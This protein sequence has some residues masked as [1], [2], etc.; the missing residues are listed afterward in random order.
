MKKGFVHVLSGCI[1]AAAIS[2]IAGMVCLA[3]V[4]CEVVVPKGYGE[5]E[6]NYP[7]VY[8]MPEDGYGSTDDKLID[9]F[10]PAEVGG[11]EMIWVCPTFTDE[12]DP[13][14][15]LTQLV[16][17]IDA[18]YQ[19]IPDTAYR[20]IVGAGSGGYLAYALGM[21]EPEPELFANIASV[22]GNFV[23]EDNP[24]YDTYGDVYEKINRLHDK[25]GTFYENYYTYMDAPSE[26]DW[27]WM[28]YST[29]NI[30]LMFL[31]WN[32]LI[33]LTT[34]EFTVREGVYDEAF[35]QES[36]ARITDRLSAK[37]TE[38][39]AEGSLELAQPVLTGDE[40]VASASYALT[41]TDACETFGQG[42]DMLVKIAVTDAQTGEVISEEKCIERMQAQP[43][44]YEG[45][46]EIENP[47]SGGTALVQ[48]SVNIFGYEVKLAEAKLIR[49][50]QTGE[51]EDEQLIDLM[52]SWYFQYVGAADPYEGETLDKETFSSWP[53]VLPTLGNWE[54]GFG[55]VTKEWWA[56][57]G[58]GWYARSFTVPEDFPQDELILSIGYMD[59]RG[60]VY[61]NGTRVGATGLDEHGQSTD[62]TTWAV[63]SHYALDPA[64]LNYGGENQIL[65]HVCNDPP[66]GAGGW[67]NGP[68]GIYSKAAF[69]RI[70]G[71]ASR[72]QEESYA[73]ALAASAQMEKGTVEERYMV[74]L[75]K[76]YD[77][78]DRFYPTVYL[79]HQYNSDHTSYQ[80][81]HI[82]Q[83]LDQAIEAGELEDM[84]VVVPNSSE[85]SF[86]LGDWERMV[87]EELVPLIDDKYRTIPDARYRL[88]AGASMGGQGAFGIALRNPDVFSGAISFFG[89]FSMGQN[90]SPNLIA[91][92]E[93][94]EY[95]RYFSLYFMCGNQDMYGFEIPAIKLDKA[96]HEKAVP[97]TFFVE[98]GE[99]NSAFYLP[100]FISALST[101][102]DG[103]YHSDEGLQGIAEGK[104]QTEQKE[105]KLSVQASLTVKDDVSAYQNQIPKS[106]YTQEEVQPLSGRLILE[107]MQD[108]KCVDQEEISGYR[109]E[110]GKKETFTFTLPENVDPAKDYSISW[111]MAVLDQI[112]LLDQIA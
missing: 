92:D 35:K 71:G 58:W 74:Y 16:E 95:L 73:S 69:D 17:Q 38:G 80:T 46:V 89:A 94:A 4:P 102:R 7:V 81:D 68:V 29:N 62:E 76:D 18:N 5:T 104:L 110:G 55:N 32:N 20:A 54:A 10:N 48:L 83:L 105:E 96:L 21:T 6:Q 53:Q 108:G 91:Q 45:T 36:F 106:S 15:Q 47:L 37:F 56:N 13:K 66:Y 22:R 39:L 57:I 111:K 107:V 9:W 63:Y 109:L 97:H 2:G 99:H 33:P 82:D 59:D 93:S 40:Q 101:T 42:G 27:S 67:Y 1:A 61:V 65:V 79:L 3:D 100:Y 85:D 28:D 70:N 52:G 77:E 64:L 112:I 51:A 11:M 98:N 50:M 25:D 87:T 90:A 24:W 49:V 60:E 75:P 44:T 34:R 72:L 78:S 26:D 43:G 103:M 88:T 86:W 19:T 12:D 84:I 31:N 41:I 23:G 14:Q 30:G 8:L